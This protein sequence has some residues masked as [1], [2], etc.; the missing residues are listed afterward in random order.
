M[1]KLILQCTRETKEVCNLFLLLHRV[2]YCLK[3]RQQV[4]AINMPQCDCVT[5]FQSLN[6]IKNFHKTWYEHYA[7]G[8]K[9]TAPHFSFPAICNNNTAA[10]QTFDEKWPIRWE[11]F[12]I[13]SFSQHCSVILCWKHLS[14]YLLRTF[15]I[16]GMNTNW[17]RNF[18]IALWGYDIYES[19][20]LNGYL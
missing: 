7:T 14:S 6:Q 9:P 1:L 12:G 8:A 20:K 10:T 13:S 2:L 11:D 15:Q 18:I 3:Q 16:H 5:P 17:N 4:Y 19:F